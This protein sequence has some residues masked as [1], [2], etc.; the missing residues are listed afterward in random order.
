MTENPDFVVNRVDDHQANPLEGYL[1]KSGGTVTG[2]LEVNGTQELNGISVARRTVSAT[3][4]GSPEDG[5]LW[6]DNSTPTWIAPT[7]TNSWGNYGGGF[8]TA[9]YVKDAMGFVHL[10]GLVS[11][12]SVAA[13]FTLPSGYRPASACIFVCPCN[14]TASP[15]GNARV[16]VSAGGAVSLVSYAASSNNAWVSL[17]GITF[18]TF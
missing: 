1:P 4:P 13:M 8:N 18:A 16:D 9:G 6:V 7:F 15:P 12:G 3:A 17:D 10:R 5:D 11:S 14:H 2:D